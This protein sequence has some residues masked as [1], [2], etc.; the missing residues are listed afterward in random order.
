MTD[1]R[2]PLLRTAACA[3]LAGLLALPAVSVRAADPEEKIVAVVNDEAISEADLNN[4]MKLIMLASNYPDS[5]EVRA[6]LQPQVLRVLIDDQL[7][8]QEAKR[9][10]LTVEKEE[11]DNE[12]KAAAEQNHETLQQLKEVLGKQGVPFSTMEKQMLAQ[13]SWRKVVQK[14]I[15]RRV[16]ITDD[17]IDAAYSK[18]MSAVDKKQYLVAEIFL[19]VDAPSDDDRVKTF[20]NNIE[21]QLQHGANFAEL[22]RQFSQAAGAAQGGDLGTVQ[23]GELPDPIDQQLK[24]LEPGTVSQPIRTQNGY[25]IILLRAKGDALEGDQSLAEVHLKNVLVPFTKQPTKEDLPRLV[26][27]ARQ[28]GAGLPNCAAVDA[29]GHRDGLG[30]D[31]EPAGQLVK[32]G[33][34]PRGIGQVVASLQVNQ[35][36]QPVPTNDGMMMFMVCARKDPPKRAPPT[37]EQVGNQLYIDRLD[38]QQQRYLSDLRSSGYVDIRV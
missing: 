9:L 37:K 21:D 26:E 11:V 7:R 12:L 2:L 23:D 14:E 34:L 4:R 33:A 18:M 1:F 28:I 38:M 27:E 6:K 20:A 3:M 36:S 19:T 32:V 29:K 31:L 8:I 15:R 35:M 17:E 16:E 13:V 25:H 24:K 10:K 30:G 22:A 5:P